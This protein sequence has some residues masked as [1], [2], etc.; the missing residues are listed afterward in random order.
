MTLGNILNILLVSAV[1]TAASSP[2]YSSEARSGRPC[3]KRLNDLKGTRNFEDLRNLLEK[4]FARSA[5][6]E[7]SFA[8]SDE[9]IFIKLK[10]MPG[11]LVLGKIWIGGGIFNKPEKHDDI[12]KVCDRVDHMSMAAD[13]KEYTLDSVDERSLTFRIEG[14]K[15]SPATRI[16][17]DLAAQFK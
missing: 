15:F 14:Y 9:S 12:V 16:H 3:A 4:S 13:G 6:S 11:G 5:K 7:A 2:A 1:L 8:S 10:K 17:P